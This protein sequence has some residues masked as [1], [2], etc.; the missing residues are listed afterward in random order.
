MREQVAPGERVTEAE[1]RLE[2]LEAP[3]RLGVARVALDDLDDPV[4]VRVAREVGHPVRG[5][6]LLEVHVGD[7]W[8]EVVRVQGLVGRDVSELDASSA[9][10]VGDV[11]F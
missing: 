8:A 9:S 7:G 6:L 10:N 2:R 11:L 5:H 1:V 3:P 4:V